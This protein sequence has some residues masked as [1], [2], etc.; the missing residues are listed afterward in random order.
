MAGQQA[1]QNPK[2]FL[3]QVLLHLVLKLFCHRLSHLTLLVCLTSLFLSVSPHSSCLSHLTLLVCLTSL[4]LSVSPHSSCLSHLTL[5]VCLTSL[6]LSV[7]STHSP[8]VINA[9]WSVMRDCRSFSALHW[10]AA[11]SF[12]CSVCSL[13]EL[14]DFY[15]YIKKTIT[16]RDGAAVGKWQPVLWLNT[17]ITANTVYRSKPSSN[18]ISRYATWFDDT[19][20]AV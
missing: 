13:T 7:S 14:N 5:L 8:H 4:F 9:I 10:A 12:N 19:E 16:V 2:Y 18:E 3:K 15:Y 6:F 1:F 17:G 11:F 20:R